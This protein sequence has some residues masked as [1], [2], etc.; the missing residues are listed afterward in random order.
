MASSTGPDQAPSEDHPA[1]SAPG[2]NKGSVTRSQS[3]QALDTTTRTTP[4]PPEATMDDTNLVHILADLLAEWPEEEPGEPEETPSPNPPDTPPPG[5]P[6]ETPSP[7]PPDTPPPPPKRDATEE[8]ARAYLR[9][10]TALDQV[11]QHVQTWQEGVP[12]PF[13]FVPKPLFFPKDVVLRNFALLV[14]YLNT[15]FQ[16]YVLA[17][18][19]RTEHNLLTLVTMQDQLTTIP[20]ET[21]AI[22]LRRQDR[23]ERAR[24]K[25]KAKKLARQAAAATKATNQ[26]ATAPANAAGAGCHSENPARGKETQPRKRFPSITFT[27]IEREGCASRVAAAAAA[28]TNN[29]N[30]PAAAP[31]NT[32]GAGGPPDHA[33]NSEEAGPTQ[34]GSGDPTVTPTGTDGLDTTTPGTGTTDKLDRILALVSDLSS[35][36]NLLEQGNGRG[37]PGRDP[38]PPTHHQSGYDQRNQAPTSRQDPGYQ[39]RPGQHPGYQQRPGQHPGHWTPRLGQPGQGNGW[40]GLDKGPHPPSH[41]QNGHNRRYQA[42]TERGSGSRPRPGQHPWHNNRQQQHQGHG[43]QTTRPD[44]GHGNRQQQ[45]QQQHQGNRQQQHQGNRQQ[46]HLGG[47]RQTT[48]PDNQEPWTHHARQTPRPCISLPARG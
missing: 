35:R 10:A 33:G 39:Q 23:L 6:E 45:Q 11:R 44:P 17:A 38:H 30:Q 15:A 47:G 26:P 41:L 48:R 12:R 21:K 9:T 27:R 16:K 29:T 13:Q 32:T 19:D 14:E 28:A 36:I 25:K 7:N 2:P 4:A 5:E 22:H 40:R 18:L 31:A 24:T 34:P 1:M 46:Q 8:E 37:G 3:R 42:P 43:R 20:P